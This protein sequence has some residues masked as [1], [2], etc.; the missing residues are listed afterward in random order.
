MKVAVLLEKNISEIDAGIQKIIDGSGTIFLKLTKLIRPHKK[1]KLF[2]QI[3]KTCR[4]VVQGVKNTL[5]MH[6]KKKKNSHTEQ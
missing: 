4:F 5:I 1:Q 6:I 3:I 2:S